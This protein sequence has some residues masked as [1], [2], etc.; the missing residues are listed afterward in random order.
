MKHK[1]SIYIDTG[2]VFEYETDSSA[3]EHVSSI[4]TGGYRSVSDGGV[5]THWPPHRIAKV[6]ATGC[7]TSYPDNV[8]G[9]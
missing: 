3:R 6:K 9:T 8:R 2:D 7:D 1:I 4:V 5:L